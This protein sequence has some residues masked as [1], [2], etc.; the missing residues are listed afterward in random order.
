MKAYSAIKQDPI[1]IR[2]KDGLNLKLRIRWN[3]KQTTKTEMDG[4]SR[5]EYEY[6]E[7]EILHT[8]PDGIKLE[9]FNLY[10]KEKISELLSEAK[11]KVADEPKPVEIKTMKT[12]TVLDVRQA[13]DMVTIAAEMAKEII[14]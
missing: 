7:E 11:A 3:E 14:K 9:D 10:L 2:D 8:V 6:D 12:A 4:K 5:I 1:W 13:M